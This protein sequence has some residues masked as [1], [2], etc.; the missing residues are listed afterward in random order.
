MRVG[1]VGKKAGMSRVFTDDGRS[2]PVTLIE[3]SPNRVVQVKTVDNDGYSAIQVTAGSK[4]PVLVNKPQAGHFAKAQVEAGRGLWEFRVADEALDSFQV[5][6]ELKVDL[7]Q[8]GQKVDVAGVTKGK[9]FQG[10][11][12]RHG[13]SMGDA[14]HGN[15]LSHRAPG[16]IGQRQ[17]PGRVFKGKKMAGHM[18]DEHQSVLNLEVVKVDLE[19]GLIAIKGSVPGA[20]GGDVVVRPA[21]KA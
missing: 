14:T 21:A 15:S 20:P 3:A 2:V 6:A 10:T 5:G 8:V 13:F 12:K 1:L 16:S 9:G 7:F 17:T 4:R 11:V 19:R 18:G